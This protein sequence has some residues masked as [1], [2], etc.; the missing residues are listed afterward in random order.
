MACQQS[1]VCHH[2]YVGLTGTCWRVRVDVENGIVS[3]SRYSLVK[4]SLYS[5]LTMKPTISSFI[6]FVNRGQSG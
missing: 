4:V 1:F 2:L 3:V 5:L 6:C